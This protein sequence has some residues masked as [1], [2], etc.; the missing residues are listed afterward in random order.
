R[1]LRLEQ[2]AEPAPLGGRGLMP[3]RWLFDLGLDPDGEE[4]WQNTDEEDAAPSPRRKYEQV[5][6]RGKAI[7]NRPRA[8][9]KRERFASM[10]HREGFR[11]EGGTRRPLAAKTKAE[12][13]AKNRQ[14]HR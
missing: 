11:H 3:C 14:L 10:A 12:A 8:L 5:D 6:E 13:N 1:D 4:G 7:S 2:R 9:H